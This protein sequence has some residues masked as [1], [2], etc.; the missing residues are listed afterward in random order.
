MMN[1]I[2]TA[3]RTVWSRTWVERTDSKNTMTIDIAS[4]DTYICAMTN[5]V[6]G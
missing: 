6:G 3:H 4:K 2:G 1:L 5:G